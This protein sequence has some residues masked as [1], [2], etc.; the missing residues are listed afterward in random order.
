MYKRQEEDS[1]EDDLSEIPL[2]NDLITE[3]A[4]DSNAAGTKRF[5]QATSS[6]AASPA[7]YQY[8]SSRP[9]RKHLYGAEDE[10]GLTGYGM[11][12]YETDPE[13]F[14]DTSLDI[15]PGVTE[16]PHDN[17]AH[18]FHVYDHRVP[19]QIHFNKRDMGLTARENKDYSAYGDTQGDAT[20]CLLYTSRCV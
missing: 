3:T 6:N 5:T 14:G 12:N 19:G 18:T 9:D 16:G 20:L 7:V 13:G 8:S 1:E 15:Q 10:P 11:G 2:V 4:T 17:L